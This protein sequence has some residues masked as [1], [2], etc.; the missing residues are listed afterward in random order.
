[1][2]LIAALAAFVA[3]SGLA[4]AQEPVPVRV[5]VQ[6]GAVVPGGDGYPVVSLARPATNG[7]GVMACTGATD[8]VTDEDEFVFVG[9]T[10]VWL[11]SDTGERYE[12]ATNAGVS[13]SGDFI[14]HVEP[15]IDSRDV[16]VTSNGVLIQEGDPA[17]GLPGMYISAASDTR[18]LPDGTAV[19]YSGY[20]DTPGGDEVANVLYRATDTA[21]PVIDIV[22][23]SGDIVDGWVMGFLHDWHYSVSEDGNQLAQSVLAVRIE[24]P[25]VTRRVVRVSQAVVA[26]EEESTGAGDNWDHFSFKDVNNLGNYILAGHTDGDEATDEFLAYNGE[27]VIREGDTVG[28]VT[29]TS[30]ADARGVCLDNRNHAIFLWDVGYI[31]TLFAAA[32][33]A[34][35]TEAVPVLTEGDTVDVDGDGVVDA[36]VTRIFSRLALAGTG[37]AFVWV[38]LDYGAG[39][40]GAV[41]GLEVFTGIFSDGFDSGDTSRW[42]ATMP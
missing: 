8:R 31:A 41:I 37:V 22:V 39:D 14:A 12:S 38:N 27:I 32:D 34:M 5:I 13:D 35:L 20:S 10:I 25:H 19:W 30:P 6:V 24:P 33:A 9:D 23:Q 29:L 7:M 36:T 26:V 42:S 3:L 16:L 11:G 17:P 2:R 18:M 15:E 40:V 4:S 1:M 28:G 21:T